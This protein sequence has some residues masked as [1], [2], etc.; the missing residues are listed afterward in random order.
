MTLNSNSMGPISH[1]LVSRVAL[2]LQ[3]F[4]L[5]L[6]FVFDIVSLNTVPAVLKL[7]T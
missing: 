7:H 2:L 4:F 3:A 1:G 5:F 6:N